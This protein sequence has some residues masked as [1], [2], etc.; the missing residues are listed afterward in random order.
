MGSVASSKKNMPVAQTK[1]AVPQNGG[2]QPTQ[3]RSSDTGT[4][5][6]SSKVG[7]TIPTVETQQEKKDDDT[8]LTSDTDNNHHIPTDAQIQKVEKRKFFFVA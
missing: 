1:P 8:P 7:N 5:Q 2:S 6:Q 4:Q 3:S